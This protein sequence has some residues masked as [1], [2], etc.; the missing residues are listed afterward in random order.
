MSGYPKGN[1]ERHEPS[2]NA[3]N[4]TDVV[5]LLK[6]MQQ[7]LVYL[8]RKIDTLIAAGASGT[9]APRPPFRDRPYSKPFRPYGNSAGGPSS[10]G[11]RGNNFRPD[12]ARG[13]HREGGHSAGGFKKKPFYGKREA[14]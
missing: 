11:Y 12:A 10:G 1:D 5:A 8:E 6:K 2:E 14:R 7:Q 13:G 4:E 3:G 9:G